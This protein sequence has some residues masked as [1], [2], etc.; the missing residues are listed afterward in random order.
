MIYLR[1]VILLV[2]VFCSPLFIV[3]T[4]KSGEQKTPTNSITI[5]K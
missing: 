2:G 4:I 5:R 3:A 1:I